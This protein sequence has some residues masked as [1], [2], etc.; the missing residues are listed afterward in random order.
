MSFFILIKF[1]NLHK[2]YLIHL[3]AKMCDKQHA[4]CFYLFKVHSLY[5]SLFILL[6]ENKLVFIHASIGRIF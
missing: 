5:V 3:V 1:I 4:N 6:L 2:L